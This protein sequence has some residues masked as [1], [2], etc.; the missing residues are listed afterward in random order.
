MHIR[1]SLSCCNT[2]ASGN[3][4]MDTMYPEPMSLLHRRVVP[5]KR[6]GKT[7]RYRT[8]PVTFSEIQEVDEENL[9]DEPT[10]G[11]STRSEQDINRRFEE[12]IRSREKILG[13]I[14]KSS[15]AVDENLNATAPLSNGATCPCPSPPSPNNRFTSR[16]SI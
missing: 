10:A 4:T 11:I 7:S 13:Q 6:R 12:F 8:Q 14:E 9:E 16:P 1:S 15:A 3:T 2:V 5:K